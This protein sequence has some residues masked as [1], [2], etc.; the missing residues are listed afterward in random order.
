MGASSASMP[1]LFRRSGGG[2]KWGGRSCSTRASRGNDHLARQGE[3]AGPGEVEGTGREG[4][5][6]DRDEAVGVEYVG[7][8]PEAPQA[9]DTDGGVESDDVAVRPTHPSP[10]TV[11]VTGTVTGTVSPPGLVRPSGQVMSNAQGERCE[12][13]KG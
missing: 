6:A 7:H 4:R 3:S 12:S 10:V 2:Q 1:L 9:A 11:T 13:L 5:V 8:G